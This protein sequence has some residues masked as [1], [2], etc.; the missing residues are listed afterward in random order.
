VAAVVA[1]CPELSPA[2]TTVQKFLG[3]G[4][5]NQKHIAAA[6]N[7]VFFLEDKAEPA[8]T[9]LIA[10]ARTRKNPQGALLDAIAKGYANDHI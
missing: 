10:W 6:R 2:W 5:H 9:K 7:W 3:T 8:V 4:S 1:A